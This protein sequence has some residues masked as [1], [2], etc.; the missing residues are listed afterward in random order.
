MITEAFDQGGIE[1]IKIEAGQFDLDRLPVDM[2]EVL[3]KS[4]EINRLQ[5]QKRDVSPMACMV[6]SAL[7]GPATE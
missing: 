3:S 1:I 6:R 7:D 4:L 5:A 2:P